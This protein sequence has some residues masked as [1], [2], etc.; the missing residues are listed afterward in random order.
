MIESRPLP[1]E[2]E[3]VPPV[4]V[5]TCCGLGSCG[6]CAPPPFAGDALPWEAGPGWWGGRF[7]RTA[8]LCGAQ[9]E[10]IFGSLQAG[11]VGPALA[12]ALFAETLAL[13]SLLAAAGAIAW[14]VAPGLAERAMGTPAALVATLVVFAGA[15]LSMLL[16]HLLWGVSL[17]LGGRQA[18]GRLDLRQGAR[19]GLYA[20]A[21]D[22]LT[23]PL[24]LL[25]A[26]LSHGPGPG[27]GLVAAAA[28]AP[29]PAQQAY[30][31]SARS[32]H[33]RRRALRCATAVLGTAAL[34]AAAALLGGLLW[35]SRQLGY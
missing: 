19:F 13:A 29:R 12:F 30:L 2:D 1:W 17:D 16:L 27:L 8:V 5:C 14:L 31:G 23:S 25:C 26:V 7:W 9:P 22:V 4:A 24:G 11:A 21:W 3:G 34:F 28:R 6:G 32:A 15:V 20:C 33:A 35:I 18:G 10:R